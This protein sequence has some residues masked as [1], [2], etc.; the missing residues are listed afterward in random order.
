[1]YPNLPT[2]AFRFY[3]SKEDELLDGY[4]ALCAQ[5]HTR[6]PATFGTLCKAPYE[7]RPLLM[8]A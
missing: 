1:L 7:V 3:A 4:R 6:L 5:I 8:P 2:A